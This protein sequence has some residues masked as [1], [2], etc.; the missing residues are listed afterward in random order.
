MLEKLGSRQAS[1][2]VEEGFGEGGVLTT[3]KLVRLHMNRLLKAVLKIFY[4]LSK[5]VESDKDY[6]PIDV[7]QGL[8]YNN[9]L[10]DIAKMYDLIA[11]Y[12]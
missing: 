12:G 7:Y 6:L 8:V 1:S 10:F 9:W 3:P 4:R 11:I 5:P 2:Y